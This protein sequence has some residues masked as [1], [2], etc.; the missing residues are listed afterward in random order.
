[1]S[2]R[3]SPPPPSIESLEAQ[4]RLAGQHLRCLNIGD[5]PGSDYGP[6]GTDAYSVAFR[7]GGKMYE[8][9]VAKDCAPGLLEHAKR[10]L[11]EQ[12]LREIRGRFAP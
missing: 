9:S 12:V 8:L 1:M 3:R 7:H 10:N 2:G 6:G 5:V 4:V 11:L